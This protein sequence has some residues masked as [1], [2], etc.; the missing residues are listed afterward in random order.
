[1]STLRPVPE[2]LL[3]TPGELVSFEHRRAITCLL[4]ILHRD[5][6]AGRGAQAS[7]VAATEPRRRSAELREEA[8]FAASAEVFVEPRKLALGEYSRRPDRQRSDAQAASFFR[9]RRARC[10]VAGPIRRVAAPAALL[11]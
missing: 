8:V 4:A 10:R 9:L 7:K 2:H 11:S 5:R 3:R 1:M 6:S